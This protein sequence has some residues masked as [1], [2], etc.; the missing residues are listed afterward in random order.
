MAHFDF[1]LVFCDCSL[2]DDE[3]LDV[4][5]VG[6]TSDTPADL[7]HTCLGSLVDSECYELKSFVYKPSRIEKK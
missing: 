4:V 2:N 7:I 3:H 6:T 1:E 5:F